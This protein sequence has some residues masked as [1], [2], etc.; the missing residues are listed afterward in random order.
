MIDGFEATIMEMETQKWVTVGSG[1]A[2]EH[3]DYTH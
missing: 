1:R 2:V 3:A